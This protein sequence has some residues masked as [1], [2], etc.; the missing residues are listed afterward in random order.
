MSVHAYPVRAIRADY[1]RAGIGMA[2]CLAPLAVSGVAWPLAAVFATF[3]ALFAI[4]GL[5]VMGRQAMRVRVTATG[6]SADGWRTVHIAWGEMSA[7]S[8]AYYS[9]RREKA[10]GWMQLRLKGRVGTVRVE[11]TIDG[12]DSL[13]RTA[14]RAAG[15]N[16]VVLDLA[17]RSNLGALGIELAEERA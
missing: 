14:A 12:F 1:M 7:M 8:L 5:R 4:F 11:S 6:V 17:T 13:V 16:G 15:A 3:A 9:T 10:K 2:C